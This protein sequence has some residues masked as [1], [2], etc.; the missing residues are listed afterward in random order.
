MEFAGYFQNTYQIYLFLGGAAML[1]VL[2]VYAAGWMKRWMMFLACLITLIITGPQGLTNYKQYVEFNNGDRIEE[3]IEVKDIKYISK[4]TESKKSTESVI[5]KVGGYV[6]CDKKS[7]EFILD[8]SCFEGEVKPGDKYEIMY[9]RT[10]KYNII[11]DIEKIN[12]VRR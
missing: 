8:S 6:L 3:I 11:L 4:D 9:A 7:R 5:K 12:N 1:F 2:G 10:S